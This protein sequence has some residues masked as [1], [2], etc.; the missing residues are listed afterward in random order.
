MGGGWCRRGAGAH[1][2]RRES[3]GCR[4]QGAGGKNRHRAHGRLRGGMGDTTGIAGIGL[5]LGGGETH[6]EGMASVG[7][8]RTAQVQV[9]STGC[10]GTGQVQQGEPGGVWRVWGAGGSTGVKGC[11]RG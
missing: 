7:C 6:R 4:S 5:E 8:R 11:S 10:R 1:G 9:A 2:D 3:G